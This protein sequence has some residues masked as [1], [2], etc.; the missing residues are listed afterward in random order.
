[1]FIPY[2]CM[3]MPYKIMLMLKNYLSQHEISLLFLLLLIIIATT[4]ITTIPT[5][6]PPLSSGEE[7]GIEF[8]IRIKSMSFLNGL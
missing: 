5:T 8:P 3:V 1:M 2:N 6:F 4:T 7:Y